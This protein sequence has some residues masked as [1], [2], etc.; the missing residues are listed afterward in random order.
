MVKN[1][2]LVSGKLQSG[3]NTFVNMLMEELKSTN[4]KVGFDFFAKSVK[5]QSKDIFKNLTDYLNT[6]SEKYNIP[7][8]YTTED[9]WYESKNHITRILLQSYGTDIFRDMVDANHWGKILKRRLVSEKNEDIMFITDV[10]FKS[11]ISTISDKEPMRHD[12]RTITPNYN[13]M[14]IRINRN[15]YERTDDPIFTHHSEID[16]DDYTDWDVLINNDSDLNSLSKQA[17][18]AKEFILKHMK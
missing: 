15:N 2:I 7:E 16:L 5:D 14:K 17:K 3:K 9:N 1:V 13:V 4:L 10:R 11:E 18:E 6:I 12:Y 8:I